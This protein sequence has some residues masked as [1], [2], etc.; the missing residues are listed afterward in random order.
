[1]EVGE[2]REREGRGKGKRILD[3]TL[4]IE[5]CANY[6]PTLNSVKLSLYL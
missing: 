6:L 1:V 2:G 4:M 3:T 5:S